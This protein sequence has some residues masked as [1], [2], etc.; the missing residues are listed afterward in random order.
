MHILS[1][2]DV[3]SN[4]NDGGLRHW[5]AFNNMKTFF[6]PSGTDMAYFSYELYV[7]DCSKS[8]DPF[9]IVIIL[10]NMGHYFLDT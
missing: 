4:Y 10:Y 2:V 1:F 9:Y 7:T 5:I 6:G 8:I 3:V